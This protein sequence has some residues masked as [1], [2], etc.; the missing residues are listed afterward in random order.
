M[1]TS[2]SQ[3]GMDWV[4]EAEYDCNLSCFIV[5]RREIREKEGLKI[6]RNKKKQGRN[7]Q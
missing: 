6:I 3:N 2:I 4:Q 5:S 1:R 7:G